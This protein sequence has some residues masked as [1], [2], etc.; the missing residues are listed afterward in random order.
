MAFRVIDEHRSPKELLDEQAGILMTQK[1]ADFTIRE[2]CSA[3]GVSIGTFYNYYR[4]KDEVILQRPSFLSSFLE[5]E[6]EKNKGKRADEQLFALA[7]AH[8][9]YVRMRGKKSCAEV[10]RCM[11]AL[12]RSLDQEGSAFFLTFRSA[13]EQGVRD[14]LFALPASADACAM[15]MVMLCRGS[16]FSWCCEEGTDDDRLREGVEACR[17][18]VESFRK[19]PEE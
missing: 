9:D 8:M 10:Y 5:A 11:L 18:L 7:A 3:A 17:H 15:M 4:N 2:L 12:P 13:L 1:G 16:G 14:G 19:K 6:A